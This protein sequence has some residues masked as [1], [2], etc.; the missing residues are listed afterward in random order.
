MFL[1]F[2]EFYFSIFSSRRSFL[3]FPY[4]CC[5]CCIKS[6]Y[7]NRRELACHSKKSTIY[8]VSFRFL[9][10]GS[11]DALYHGFRI[12]NFLFRYCCCCVCV[13][14]R[15]QLWIEIFTMHWPKS[16][17]EKIYIYLISWFFIG[18]SGSKGEQWVGGW[19][20]N[21]RGKCWFGLKVVFG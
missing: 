15:C 9:Q 17:M 14:V 19:A 11:D 2:F 21:L 1:N 7:Y 8:F 18:L 4:Y 13:C 10:N 20:G 16:T 12:S 3:I 5:C 6:P